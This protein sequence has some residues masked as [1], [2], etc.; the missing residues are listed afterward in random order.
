MRVACRSALLHRQKG[1]AEAGREPRLGGTA[2]LAVP[3]AEA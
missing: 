1:D 2:R 3:E